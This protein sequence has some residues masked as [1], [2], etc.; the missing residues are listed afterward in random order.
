M[1][2][3]SPLLILAPVTLVYSLPPLP[4]SNASA[5]SNN[6]IFSN[7]VV[8]ESRSV[9]PDGF[10]NSGAASASQVLNLRIGLAQ[11]NMSGLARRHEAVSTPGSA[12]YGKHLSKEVVEAHVKPTNETTA[13]VE[14]WLDAKGLNAFSASP[15]GDWLAL[16]MTVAQ[17]STLFDAEFSVFTY[18]KTGEQLVRTLAYSL[19]AVLLGHVEF[20]ISSSSKPSVS[21][22]STA[23]VSNVT[24]R[25][26]PASCTKSI[27]PACLQAL[28]S[29]PTTKATQL[30]NSIGVTGFSN[31]F[32]NQDDLTI[33]LKSLRSDISSS[34]SSNMTSAAGP[35]ANLNMQYTVGIAT[36]VPATLISVGDASMDGFMDV[37]T[38]LLSQSNPPHVV[39]TSYGQNEGSISR[40]VATNLCNA[41]MQLGA[42]GITVLF[43]SGNGGVAG[44][45]SA[46]CTSF[47]PTFP[48]TCPYV[49][50]VGVTSM[51]TAGL[52]TAASF[53]AG[54]FSNYFA[55]P[56]YQTSAV[57]SFLVESSSLE[58][59]IVSK[60]NRSGRAFPDVAAQGQNLEFVLYGE[61]CSATTSGSATPIVASVIALLNDELIANRRPP[62]GFLNPLLYSPSFSAAFNDIVSG[63]NAGCNAQGFTAR[64]GWDP[65][66]GLGT[67][68]FAKL[69]NSIGLS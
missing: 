6:D 68:N 37:A 36:G 28:Y 53:S 14:E 38:F 33:F 63:S 60:F 67:P 7:L 20:D 3:F 8:H 62:L 66:T 11:G 61:M 32:A 50:S 52:E 59:D 58:E 64:K 47:V 26:I 25:A 57:S 69:R 10:V 29:I 21:M 15:A 9:F 12:E 4:P 1:R 65:I 22:S 18:E 19:P 31:E 5:V 54:G 48:S 2:L 35:L 56:S 43:S 42:R 30:S 23:G 24:S 17:A 40:A 45:S 44:E 41:Y 34:T 51:T 46:S 39:T 55:T 27:T 49:T 16:L 13:A